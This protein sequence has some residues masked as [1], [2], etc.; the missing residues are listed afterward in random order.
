MSHI[1]HT[2]GP[3]SVG[4]RGGCVV[5]EA[6]IPEIPEGTGHSDVRHYGGYLIAESIWRK[7]D[8]RLIA[9]APDLFVIADEIL[10][11]RMLDEFN[12]DN[13]GL[14]DR[15]PSAETARRWEKKLRAAMAK[16]TG[17]A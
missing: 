1:N 6:P 11:G 5:S 8:A 14:S 13:D 12:H 4:P 3:W 16:A 15:A 2:P 10:N 9:A 17:A 7:E